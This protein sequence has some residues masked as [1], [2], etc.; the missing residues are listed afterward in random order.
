MNRKG[1]TLIELL[2]VIGIIGLL[3]AVLMPVISR[4][5]QQAKVLVVNSELYNISVALE[6]YS[7]DNR[8]QYPPTRADCNP[9]ARKHFW[10]LPQELVKEGYMPGGKSGA[11]NFA[12]VE[13]KF[14]R[15]YTYKYV[16]VGKRL[17][18]YGTPSTQYL[19]ICEGF[20]ERDTP[21]FKMY[22][23]PK[24]SPITWMLISTGP[25]FDENIMVKNG[26]PSSKHFWYSP[27]KR[28]GLI[29]RA[30]LL[31]GQHIGTFE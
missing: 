14:N 15:G 27:A 9:D 28:S 29:V 11:V 26:F 24:T 16:M 30:R 23:D 22:G 2:T 6:A 8:N 13:D 25:K 18:Y 10:A 20:P 5:R 12:N 21:K 31:R 3:L 19:Q 17:D 4:A 1:F 7:M